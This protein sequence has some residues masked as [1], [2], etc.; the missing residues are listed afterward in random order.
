MDDR[1]WILDQPC[2]KASPSTEG[3]DRFVYFEPSTDDLDSQREIVN[4]DALAKS[5]QY[6]LKFG[7]VDIDHLSLIGVRLGMTPA[8]AKLY[9][10]GYPVS[11]TVE[12]SVMVKAAIYRGDSEQARQANIF[13]DSLTKQNPPKR[14]YPSIGG[15]SLEKI[16]GDDGCEIKRLAWNNTAMVS[17]PS[18]PVNRAVRSVSIIAPDVFVKAINAGYSTDSTALVGGEALRRQSIGNRVLR[19]IQ[20]GEKE[21]MPAIKNYLE[22]LLAV[23]KNGKCPSCQHLAVAPRLVVLSNHFQ[24]CDGYSADVADEMARRMYEL[25]GNKLYS[26]VLQQ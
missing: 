25:I 15:K 2:M 18:V 17:Q 3:D 11:V 21:W 1:L 4:R 10:I 13:W 9:E 19:E 16:C 12:P 20:G 5:A 6:Y 14:Y 23:W 24:E 8:E 22:D 7:N 26:E